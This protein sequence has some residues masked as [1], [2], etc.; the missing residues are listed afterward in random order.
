MPSSVQC[1]TMAPPFLSPPVAVSSSHKPRWMTLPYLGPASDKLASLLKRYNYRVC[2]YPLTT[3]SQLVRLKDH[4]SKFDKSGIYQ[5]IC[6]HC[7]AVHIGQ[8]GRKLGR[9]TRLAE[10][11][12]ALKPAST[13]KSA[14]AHHCCACQHDFSKMGYFYFTHALKAVSWTSLRKRRL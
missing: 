2:F 10:H 12:A 3:V 1:W 9:P 4:S 6:V 13:K 11:R 7:Q 14:F 8:T 5:L